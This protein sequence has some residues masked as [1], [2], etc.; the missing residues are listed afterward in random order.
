MREL[1]PLGRSEGGTGGRASVSVMACAAVG[2]AGGSSFSDR[3]ARLLLAQINRLRVGQ[4]FCDVRLEVGSEAFSVHRLVLAAS[5]P[6]FA[7]LFAG[8]MKESGRDVVRIAGVEAGIFHTLLDFI[9]TG[10]GGA[11][12]VPV[13][14]GGRGVSVRGAE[15][16]LCG[17]AGSF[18]EGGLWGPAVGGG[19]ALAA[20][21]CPHTA[22]SGAPPSCARPQAW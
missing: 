14:E 12:G 4:S 15:V 1:C 17:G 21:G 3:H 9:Y 2:S 11:G 13:C 20:L 18:C 22:Y 7:A 10:N 19:R 8:G 16:P 5:S 6:Y